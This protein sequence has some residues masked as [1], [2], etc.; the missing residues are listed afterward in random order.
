MKLVHK[1]ERK[2]FS[3]LPDDRDP[4]APNNLLTPEQKTNTS[5]TP[6]G[7]ATN[8]KLRHRNLMFVFC[9]T[10]Q[11]DT[12]AYVSYEIIIRLRSTLLIKT[13]VYCKYYILI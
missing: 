4:W 3:K 7:Q 11:N 9:L 10:P 2:R 6:V 12:G 1:D 8:K 13:S 5:W